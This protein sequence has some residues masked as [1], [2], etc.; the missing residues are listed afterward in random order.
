MTGWAM[1][2][3]GELMDY[4][5][6]DIKP[7][8]ALPTRLAD[9][10]IAIRELAYRYGKVDLLLFEDIQ[11]QRGNV[12]TYKVLAYVQAALIMLCQEEGIEYKILSPSHWRKVLGGTW[13]RKREEQKQHA[14]EYVRQVC[15]ID[16]ESDV[17]DA[18]CIGLAG[19]KEMELEKSGFG[20]M[21]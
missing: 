4:G 11:L 10:R 7:T 14:I 21:E 8:R 20:D 17:A 3:D 1:F 13:G 2:E 18:I 9:L 15:G 12:T 6:I 16:V 5:K 19:I